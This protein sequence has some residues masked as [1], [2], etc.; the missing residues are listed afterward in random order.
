MPPRLYPPRKSA[1]ATRSARQVDKSQRRE[2]TNS[3]RGLR[4]GDAHPAEN[5]RRSSKDGG[6]RGEEAEKGEKK[7]VQLPS[8]T[9]DSG[10][11]RGPI[12]GATRGPI[13]SEKQPRKCQAD[14]DASLYR[15]LK[16]RSLAAPLLKT[17]GR[18]N[19]A[20]YLV[21]S[22]RCPPLSLSLSLSLLFFFLLFF[23]S[24]LLRQATVSSPFR[25]PR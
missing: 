16:Y 6:K 25:C 22:K 9:D 2:E 14:G 15:S 24:I 8:A 21:V 1:A 4:S 19:V 11:T 7:M 13:Y 20:R 10:P 17:G 5:E 12:K 18:S 3:P 23:S